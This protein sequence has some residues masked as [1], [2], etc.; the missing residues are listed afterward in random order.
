YDLPLDY[1]DSVT[2]KVEA[3]TVRQVRDAFRRRIHPDRL[4]TVR[5]GRQGS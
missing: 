3:V 2:A 1:L 5:V 4:V